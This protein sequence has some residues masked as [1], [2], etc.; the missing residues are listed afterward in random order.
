M[1]RKKE[2]DEDALLDK[3]AELFWRKGYN[4]TS[5]QDLVDGLGISRSSL[6]GAGYSKSRFKGLSR[7]L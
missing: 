3:A 1:A 7:W 2:F 4:G 6:Y 5:A